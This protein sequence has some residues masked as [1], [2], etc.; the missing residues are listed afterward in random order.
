MDRGSD[1][2]W[3]AISEDNKE[4]YEHLDRTVKRKV[5]EKQL[6]IKLRKAQLENSW[7]GYKE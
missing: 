6:E 5:V 4:L 1:T 2:G 7:R 3:Y